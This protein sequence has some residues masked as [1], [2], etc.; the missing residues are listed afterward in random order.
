MRLCL[1]KQ[2]AG[3]LGSDGDSIILGSLIE[4]VMGGITGLRGI[5]GILGVVGV[6]GVGLK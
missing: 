4:S 2:T 6:V 5:G 1:F 3:F